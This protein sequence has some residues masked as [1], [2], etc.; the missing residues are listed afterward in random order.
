MGAIREQTALLGAVVFFNTTGSVLAADG[1]YL[2][3]ERTCI[4]CHGPE[5]KAPV[6]TEYPL[7]AGQNADYLLNQMQ[8]IKNGARG[9]SHTAPM[10]N[11]MHLI[12]DKEMA[13]IAKWLAQIE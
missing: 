2:Y 1:A 5:G 4:A 3:K 12:S 8:D 11:V 7:L 10:K 13:I 9:N 6:M